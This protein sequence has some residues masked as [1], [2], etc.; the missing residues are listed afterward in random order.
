MLSD[1][2]FDQQKLVTQVSL[3]TSKAIALFRLARSLI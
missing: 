3:D 2:L 1:K